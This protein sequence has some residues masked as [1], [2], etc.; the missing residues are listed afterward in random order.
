[1]S[2]QPTKDFTKLP[3]MKDYPYLVIY[4]IL[5]R[6]IF[7]IEGEKLRS[8]TRSYTE[9]CVN[10]IERELEEHGGLQTLRIRF[11]ETKHCVDFLGWSR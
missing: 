1:M 10:R 9:Q 4:S 2:G 11:N 5:L 8:V 6:D 3:T 7:A